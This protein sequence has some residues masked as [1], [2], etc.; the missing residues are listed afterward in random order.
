MERDL[1]EFLKE[2]ACPKHMAVVRSN[3]GEIDSD[4]VGEC[5]T[6]GPCWVGSNKEHVS[7][8]PHEDCSGLWWDTGDLLSFIQAAT[9]R[10]VAQAE[11]N[12]A[13]EMCVCRKVVYGDTLVV[14]M[15]R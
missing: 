6:G 10:T 2:C 7:W 14:G 3:P 9:G 1:W 15:S 4:R 8:H 12:K 13:R 11:R 5:R